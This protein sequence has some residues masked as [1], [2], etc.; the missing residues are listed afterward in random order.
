MSNFLDKL[1]KVIVDGNVEYDFLSWSDTNNGHQT[2]TVTQQY[3]SRADLLANDVY[4]DI[5]DYWILPYYNGLLHTLLEVETELK[6]I[7]KS[8]IE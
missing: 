7:N 3:I 4:G 8:D 5:E 1:E 6:Y 2:I